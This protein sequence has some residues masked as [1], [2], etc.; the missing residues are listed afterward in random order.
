MARYAWDSET[1]GLLDELDRVHCLVLGDL[2]TGEILDFGPDR[3]EEGLRLL[4]ESDLA[5]A[6][7]GIWFD[8]PA[9]QKVYPWFT[10]RRDQI[11]DSLVM[12][13]LIWTNLA[14]L[15]KAKK[16]KQARQ[17]LPVMPIKP[18]W[19]SL[20]S[21]GYRLGEHKGEYT[22]GWEHWNPEMHEYC[23]QDVRVTLK[24]WKLIEQKNY[25][26]QATELEHR[27]ALIC[28]EQE[29]YGWRFDVEAA[30]Q[31]YVE[32]AEIE[33]RYCEEIV[34][35]FGA[36]FTPE[37]YKGEV[38]VKTPKRSV[39]YKDVTK[40]STWQGAPYTKVKH[41]VFNP[42]SRQQIADRLRDL[43]GW[44]PKK[45]DY[46]ESGQ[47][48]IDETILSELPY[49][50]AK[51]LAKLLTVQKLLGQLATGKQAWLKLER[52]GR[53][54]GRVNT[55]GANTGRCT[56]SSPNITQVPSGRKFMGDRCRSL[57][58]ADP[59]RVVVGADVDGLELATLAHYLQLYPGSEDYIHAIISGDKANG[60]DIHTVN[61]LA[62]GLPTRDHAKTFIYALIYGGGNQKLGEIMEPTAGPRKKAQLGK[63]MREALV[64]KVPSLGQLTEFAADRH[65]VHGWIEGL[66]GRQLITRSAHS[67]L[68]TLLQGAGA[69]VC[70]QWMVEVEDELIRTK[71]RAHCQQIA[72]VH[73]ELQF[74]ADED[75]AEDVADVL[76]RCIP[77]A[78]EVMKLRVPISGTSSIGRSWL[79]TH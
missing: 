47:P 52:N 59:G 23:I 44:K 13:R 51:D 46:T 57:F 12:S 71:L 75:Y 72:T 33:D 10:L 42:R 39:N 69:V 17:G 53:I 3:I 34:G 27:V 16:A 21:W 67:A 22:G 18:G 70:K 14:D 8:I 5:V 64:G 77:M 20:E 65:E 74:E 31:L 45:N 29:R 30:Q 11:R 61:Q 50:E 35:K 68:N 63:Q 66:D 4:M 49:P 2:D 73:D 79:E 58:I 55:N 54:H 32:L 25:S 62:V 24:L 36:W 56:H 7:N 41:I 1:N 48:K 26:E 19:H 37:R 38:V 40:A 60:T 43:Y 6:H 28:A 78:G 15:D 9:M 76:T